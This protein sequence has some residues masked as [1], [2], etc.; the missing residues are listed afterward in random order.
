MI[1]YTYLHQQDYLVY[2]SPSTRLFCILISINKIILYT[3]LHQQDGFVYL[4]PSTL[5]PRE[6]A[7]RATLAGYGS[8]SPTHGDEFEEDYDEEEEEEEGGDVAAD[9]AAAAAAATAAGGFGAG[10]VTV[11]VRVCMETHSVCLW[12]IRRVCIVRAPFSYTP[13]RGLFNC[14]GACAHGGRVCDCVGA[15]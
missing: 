8:R 15:A 7:A 2:L 11:G 12:H 3:Y 5:S 13:T 4:S 10:F 14:R 6:Q 9:E 1:W